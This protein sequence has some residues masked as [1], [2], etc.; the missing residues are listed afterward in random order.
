MKKIIISILCIL[1]SGGCVAI[2]KSNKKDED[3]SK[4]SP[5]E[6]E[7]VLLGYL[8][9]K[10]H[11]DFEIIAGWYDDFSN[12]KLEV[13]I[14]DTASDKDA[15]SS[16]LWKVKNG[17]DGISDDYAY[18]LYRP[19]INKDIDGMIDK[20]LDSKIEYASITSISGDGKERT[21][22]IDDYDEFMKKDEGFRIVDSTIMIKNEMTKDQLEEIV[23]KLCVEFE[24]AYGNDINYSFTLQVVDEEWFEIHSKYTK[25]YKEGN[26]ALYTDLYRHLN[27][28]ERPIEEYYYNSHIEKNKK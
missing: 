9:E 25:E 28:S 11:K 1:M 19:N 4:L 12:T 14:R 18:Y 20:V 27:K 21:F 8:K 5:A 22:D 26:G 15:F 3:M 24:K 6:K 13:N 2:N 23:K 7:E 17:V 10:Y 16:V